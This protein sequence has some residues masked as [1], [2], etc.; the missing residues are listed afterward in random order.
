M[1]SIITSNEKILKLDKLSKEISDIRI[2]IMK[3]N[4]TETEKLKLLLQKFDTKLHENCERVKEEYEKHGCV[5][6]KVEPAI[7]YFIPDVNENDAILKGAEPSVIVTAADLSEDGLH[8]FLLAAGDIGKT[9]HQDAEILKFPIRKENFQNYV[10]LKLDNSTDLIGTITDDNI[11]PTFEIVVDVPML[12]GE[13]LSRE[14]SENYLENLGL[15][16]S[17]ITELAKKNYAAST[18]STTGKSFSTIYINGWEERKRVFGSWLSGFSDI[19]K[20]F[21][22]KDFE[23]MERSNRMGSSASIK[24]KNRLQGLVI[25][26][27]LLIIPQASPGILPGDSLTY[28]DLL[29]DKKREEVIKKLLDILQ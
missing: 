23:E 7:G 27:E 9:Y 4:Q 5:D 1:T 28:E 24:Q 11:I 12:L 13:N 20:R 21:S 16:V 29:S 15:Y 14:L 18:W 10:E 3:L 22:E 19:V 17:M 2:E 8:K 26:P 25:E 6:V